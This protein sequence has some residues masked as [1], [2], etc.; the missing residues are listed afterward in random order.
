MNRLDRYLIRRWLYFFIPAMVVLSTAYLAS[1]AAFTLWEYIQRGL[2]P[3]RIALHYLLETPNILYQMAPIA[4][5][6]A[7]LLTMTSMKRSGEMTAAFATGIGRIRMSAP[8]LAAAVVTSFLAFYVTDSMAPGA[9]RMSRDLVRK[10]SGA[11]SSVVGTKRIWLLEGT[12]I[13]HI[14]SVEDEGNRLTEPTILQFDGKG[15]K[16]LVLRMDADSVVWSSGSWRAKT[17]V[18]RQFSNGNLIATDVLTDQILPIHIRPKEFY[19]ARR[20]PEEMSMSELRRYILNLKTAGLPY[21]T[22]LVNSYQKLSAAA[23][24]II[25]TVFAIPVA[26][27][28]PVRG[29]V[30]MGLGLSIL[31]VL[32]FWSV[33]SLTLSLGYTGIIPPP[34]AAWSAQALFLVLGLAALTLIK[35]PRLT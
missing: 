6:I 14:N 20:R 24:S 9:N 21:T 5:L 22:Q 3:D 26:F 29:G 27:L 2:S 33:F 25:F 19:R 35:H 4:S 34:A 31:L 1:E 10:G 32:V 17:V 11:E 8:F 15:L 7:T 23:I 13:I 30:P 16:N 18:L 28:V 12:R